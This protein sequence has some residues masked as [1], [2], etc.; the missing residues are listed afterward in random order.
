MKGIF[1]VAWALMVVCLLAAISLAA[2]NYVTK[3]EIE[4]R[5]AEELREK[6]QVVFPSAERFE[7]MNLSHD[8]SS[9]SGVS[10]LEVYHAL[11]GEDRVG[12][13]L[14]VSVMGYGGEMVLLVGIS[15]QEKKIMGIQVL[16]HQETPGLGSNITEE[17]FLSQFVSKSLDDPFEI[18]RDIQ[19]VT[20]A[21]ISTK[22]VIRA[23][24]EAITYFKNLEAE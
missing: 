19:G 3:K 22:A 2:V 10:V 15:A 9:R 24:Q 17:R 13:V 21:T 12:Y 1:R 4:R 6:L 5:S 16:E 11:I 7:R 23:C 8:L 14:R 18:K 20:G